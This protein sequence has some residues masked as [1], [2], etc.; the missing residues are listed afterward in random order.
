M[1]PTLYINKPLFVKKPFTARGKEY[2]VG[3]EFNWPGLTDET[4]VKQL[5]IAR[6]LAHD[7]RLEAENHVG[8]R[9]AELGQKALFDLKDEINKVVKSR[10]T[11]TQEFQRICC[12]ASKIEDKQ[13]AH[14]RRFL[15]NNDWIKS[16]RDLLESKQ[17]YYSL[18]EKVLGS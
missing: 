14:I 8:D 9:L 18:V 15:Y 3:Q 2:K 17:D 11:N 16:D 7:E 1:I 12:K 4:T 10:T 13:R 6:Y 5:M